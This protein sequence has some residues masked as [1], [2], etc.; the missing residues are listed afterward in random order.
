MLTVHNSQNH[1]VV[2]SKTNE[3]MIL[4]QDIPVLELSR[5]ILAGSFHQ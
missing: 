4:L 3:P 5:K 1:T 2:I